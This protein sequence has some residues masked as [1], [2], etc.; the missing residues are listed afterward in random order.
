MSFFVTTGTQD[1]QI[2]LNPTV[3]HLGQTGSDLLAVIWP[4]L[5]FN[6]LSWRVPYAGQTLDLLYLDPGQFSNGRPTRSG[7]PVL[8]PFPNRIRGGRFT[9]AGREFQLPC[10][11]GTK[12]NAIHGFA[13]R[14]PWRVIDQGAGA[15]EAWVTGEFQCG[16]DAP[17]SLPLWPS[18]QRIRLT[19]RLREKVLRLEAEVSNPDRQPLPFGLGFHPYFRLPFVEGAAAAACTVQVPA[20][21]YWELQDSLPTGKLRVVDT[22][23]DLNAPQPFTELQVDDVLTELPGRKPQAAARGA[24]QV[25]AAELFPSAALYSPPGATLRLACSAGF[26][27]L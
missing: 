23:R 5:G 15:S 11:D 7:I 10:N 22:L 6:C 27:E 24:L 19:Y 3:Y 2:G 1:N 17:E 9:W 14:H 12:Q 8:F 25:G 21:M 13:C 16:L 26:R 20:G 4:A 18:D